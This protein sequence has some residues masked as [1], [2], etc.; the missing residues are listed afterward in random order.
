MYTITIGK[1][2]D[3]VVCTSLYSVNATTK[4]HLEDKYL[5]YFHAKEANRTIG[6]VV[7][8][9]SNILTCIDSLDGAGLGR[10]LVAVRLWSEGLLMPEN[11]LSLTQREVVK[12][13]RIESALILDRL[14]ELAE[15]QKD[16]D[17]N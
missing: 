9:E 5:L 15:L 12:V 11:V 7:T 16:K 3:K 8:I 6:A 10:V 17:K 14:K 4:E 1:E 2:P 13:S